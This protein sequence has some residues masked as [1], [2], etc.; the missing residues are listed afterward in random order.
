MAASVMDRPRRTIFFAT[1]NDDDYL[2]GA[3]GKPAVLAGP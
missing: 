2:Q 1:T 3:N